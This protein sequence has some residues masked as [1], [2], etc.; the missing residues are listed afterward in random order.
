MFQPSK[1]LKVMSVIFIILGVLGMIGTGFGYAMLPALENIEGVDMSLITETM[2]P[3]NLVLS[4]MSCISSVMAGIAGIRG[5]SR[6]RAV[7]FVGIYS[8]LTVVSLSQTALMGLFN[9]GVILDLAIPV[10]YWWGLYQS[11]E[12]E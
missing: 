2:T 4:I 3:L 1:L 8:L 6:K 10:L 7:V 9:F 5:K 12:K 11:E